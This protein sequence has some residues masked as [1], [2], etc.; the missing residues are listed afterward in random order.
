MIALTSPEEV[1]LFWFGPNWHDAEEVSSVQYISNRMGMWFAGENVEFDLVQKSNQDL[2]EKLSK[3]NLEEGLWD[4]KWGRLA[5][6]ILLDQFPRCIYRGT[7]RAFQHDVLTSKL[8]KQI[9]DEGWLLSYAPIYRFFLG[10]A[11]QHSEELSMQEIGVSIA[12]MVAEGY[13]P[14]LQNYFKKLKGYP[15]EHINVIR[16]FNRFPSRNIAMVSYLIYAWIYT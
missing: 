1:L 4:T 5:R 15:D 12:E 7:A 11:A 3:E 13:S 10:I 2:V 9:V 6:V 8:V 16:R 14:E